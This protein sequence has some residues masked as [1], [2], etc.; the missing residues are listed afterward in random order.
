MDET[1]AG[2]PMEA[3]E[4]RPDV[5]RM[6]AEVFA[7]VKDR[8]ANPKKG[9][10][11]NRLFDAGR[12]RIAQ[13]VGEEAIEVVLAAVSP[14]QSQTRLLEELADLTYHCLVLVADCG[15]EPVNIAEELRRRF[16]S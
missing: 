12:E 5:D 11:T 6:V 15:L 13:K 4:R 9:S 2:T 1:Q 3:D 10:Y 8:Q 7:V 14:N 16:D